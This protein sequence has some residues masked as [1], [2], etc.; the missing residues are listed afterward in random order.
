MGVVLRLRGRGLLGSRSSLWGEQVI[1]YVGSGV[2]ANPGRIP[3]VSR[4]RTAE[5]RASEQPGA[6]RGRDSAGAIVDGELAEDALHPG[7][8]GAADVCPPHRPQVLLV[9]C[10]SDSADRS[11]CARR[12][13]RRSAR[14]SAPGAA[15]GARA[16]ACSGVS[17]RIP[18][19]RR[20]R[21]PSRARHPQ[22]CA[23]SAWWMP[24]PHPRMPM[25]R[26]ARRRRR[27]RRG[28][29]PF[30]RTDPPPRWLATGPRR[31]RVIDRAHDETRVP[32]QRD[33]KR[34]QA[35]GAVGTRCRRP[36]SRPQRGGAT[37][38]LA[39]RAWTATHTARVSTPHSAHAGGRTRYARCATV[40]A[41]SSGP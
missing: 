14:R 29:S 41:S 28:P 24:S 25:P 1:S 22:V 31:Q 20:A 15:H 10:A 38:C 33:P 23:T 16:T 12:C 39:R 36:T 9:A 5:I 40:K 30:A 2:P 19:A 34:D 8:H 3:G 7:A 4:L 27:A 35:T 26:R 37:R 13:Q 6:L 32:R 18:A 21:A 11:T 17:R